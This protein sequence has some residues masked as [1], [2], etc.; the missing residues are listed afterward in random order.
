M[1]ARTASKTKV[2]DKTRGADKA[3]AAD[4]V[5]WAFRSRL[6]REAFGWRGSHLA[7]RRIDEALSEIRAIARRDPALGAEGA[8]IFLCVFRTNV[9]GVSAGT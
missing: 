6:R 2:A 9:T 4:K 3:R 8:V 7:I 5:Q 1:T